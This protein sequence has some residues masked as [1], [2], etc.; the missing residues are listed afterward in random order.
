MKTSVP[1]IFLIFLIGLPLYA[2][3]QLR[4]VQQA[5]KDQGFY[6]GQ[7]DGSPGSETSAAI[8]RFQIRNG[9]EVTGQVNPQT[10][11]A[12]NGGEPAASPIPAA[13]PV[14]QPKMPPM[15]TP[16]ESFLRNQP[17]ATAVPQQPPA[18]S[19][20]SASPQ[21]P[22]NPYAVI[23]RRTPYETAPGEVQSDTLKRA[24]MKL[25]R[26]GFYRGSI[27]GAPGNSTAQAILRYQAN[28]GI[29]E[30]GRLDMETLA[31]LDL[32]PH[33]GPSH[34][35]RVVPGPER[36]VYRGIWIH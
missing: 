27:D 4:T 10:L 9:L 36:P 14:I 2:D 22:L 25:Y 6:Y 13:T 33:N 12:I 23:F 11:A 16:P 20:Q 18:V 29:P 35:P 8:K 24:Q 26:D 32:L 17:P 7:V 30:T 19:P 21:S 15:D 28:Q 31:S 34:P 1:L 5:L 3:D